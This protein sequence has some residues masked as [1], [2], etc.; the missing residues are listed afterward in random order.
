MLIDDDDDSDGG[1]LVWISGEFLIY[2]LDILWL[3]ELKWYKKWNELF[4]LILFFLHLN[5]LIKEFI[6]IWIKERE[7]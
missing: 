2:L 6:L 3:I 4:V 5:F 7:T 1:S